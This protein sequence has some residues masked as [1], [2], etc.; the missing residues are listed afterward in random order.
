MD[1]KQLAM[2]KHLEW[3]GKIEVVARAN[4]KPGPLEREA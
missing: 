1:N 3:Q 4:Q 2:Q